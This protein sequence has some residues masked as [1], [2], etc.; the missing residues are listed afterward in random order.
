MN[1]LT[2]IIR[3]VI[4]IAQTLVCVWLALLLLPFA[5]G[6]WILQEIFKEPVYV[7]AKGELSNSFELLN[8]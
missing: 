3:L 4:G 5:F 2:A 7:N 8:Q 6:C 1:K